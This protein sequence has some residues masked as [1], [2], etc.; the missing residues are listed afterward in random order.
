[1]IGVGDVVLYSFGSANPVLATV[2]GITTQAEKSI[3][4]GFDVVGLPPHSYTLAGDTYK[5]NLSY[6]LHTIDGREL[7]VPYYSIIPTANL[8]EVVGYI[9]QPERKESAMRYDGLHETF[10]SAVEE[11]LD[12]V[13]SNGYE[14]DDI[15]WR[16]EVERG[17]GPPDVGYANIYNV[18]LLRAGRPQRRKLCFRI[19]RSEN[20]YELDV[21]IG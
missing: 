6:E 18:K 20:N 21:Y 17:D 4:Y 3:H 8:R 5:I 13:C 12:F 11:T 10:D 1:M 14:V 19:Y 9:Y 2:T 15:D 16:Y 7:I